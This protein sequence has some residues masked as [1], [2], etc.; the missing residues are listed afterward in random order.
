MVAIR[1][2]QTVKAAP[3]WADTPAAT[4][5]QERDREYK[6]KSRGVCLCGCGSTDVATDGRTSGYAAGHYQP[7]PRTRTTA[8][9]MRGLIPMPDWPGRP[10][11]RD[12]DPDLFFAP[13]LPRVA[14]EREPE[15]D[16]QERIAAA[17]AVCARC[18]IAEECL[19]FALEHDLTGVWGGKSREERRLMLRNAKACNR[20]KKQPREAGRTY[21]VG[22]EAESRR[23]SWQ[24]R[25]EGRS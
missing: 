22:C 24:R 6:R 9:V 21:C 12:A 15:A 23:E 17:K 18:P 19:R 7:G 1:K 25:K 3:P 14:G 16:R 13:N 10:A 11:C 8:A 20:C 5:M 4:T 2:I